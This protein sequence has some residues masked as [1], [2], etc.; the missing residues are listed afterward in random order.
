MKVLDWKAQMLFHYIL[1]YMPTPYS[2]VVLCIR[3]SAAMEAAAAAGADGDKK[4]AASFLTSTIKQMQDS[5]APV[6]M[7][8]R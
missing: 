3:Q 1:M 4:R 8:S 6:A 7:A 5:N 2:I